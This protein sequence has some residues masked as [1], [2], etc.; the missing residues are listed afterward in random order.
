MARVVTPV[1]DKAQRMILGKAVI[2]AEAERM[3]M[4]SSASRFMVADKISF[5]VRLLPVAG[6][7]V[8]RVITL[9]VR[10]RVKEIRRKL[11]SII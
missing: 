3:R 11:P 6:F 7:F 1:V 9:A 4:V 8:G 2:G 10:V 5:I